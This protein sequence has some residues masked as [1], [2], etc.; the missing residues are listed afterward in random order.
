MIRRFMGTLDLILIAAVGASAVFHIVA[1]GRLRSHFSGD[2]SPAP[3]AD[4]HVT[5]LRPVKPGTPDLQGKLE[6]LMR[7]AKGGDQVIVGVSSE[8]D[9]RIASAISGIEVID[10]PDMRFPNPKI[11]K[12]VPMGRAARHD[13]WILTDSE[14]IIDP[15]LAGRLRDE[16]G[17]RGL[18]T[19]GYRFVGA[20][21]WPQ[22]LDQTG[23]LSFFWPGLAFARRQYAFGAFIAV[24]RETVSGIGGWE[25][26][27]D[28]LAEDFQLG[29]RVAG[30]GVEIRLAREIIP[31]DSDPMG[32]RDWLAHQV[33]VAAT[34]RVCAPAGWAAS[35]MAHG[36]LPAILLCGLNPSETWRWV[37]LAATVAIRQ[38]TARINAGLL[39][40]RVPSLHLA[41]AA[42]S[43]LETLFW[44]ASWFVRRVRWGDS[45][46]AVANDGR[47]KR[48][49]PFG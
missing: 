7:C 16:W 31:L 4:F 17:G 9:R 14:A 35:W 30:L 15:D 6:R 36:T 26:V 19:A 5:F 44:G 42:V 43:L 32:W 20:T 24:R 3:P 1:A 25:A 8:A 38:I 33:R 11:A 41:V 46:F 39:R 29:K 37:A 49:D 23:V 21:G 48:A 13:H 47:I 34:H 40:F 18:L 2:R 45:L 12:L 22:I 10:H 28:Y 27:G